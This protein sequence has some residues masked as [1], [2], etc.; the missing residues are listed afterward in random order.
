[1][2]EQL[3]FTCEFLE[4]KLFSVVNIQHLFR[5]VGIEY[6]TGEVGVSVHVCKDVIGYNSATEMEI[7][8]V[9]NMHPDRVGT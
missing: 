8:G 1:M 7:N 3:Y 6:I 4:E 9:S 5:A 2:E